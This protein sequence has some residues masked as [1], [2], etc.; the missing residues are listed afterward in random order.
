MQIEL[1]FGCDCKIVKK[2]IRDVCPPSHVKKTQ[3]PL[4]GFSWNFTLRILFKSVHQVQLKLYKNKGIVQLDLR[5]FMTNVITNVTM[6]T[7]HQG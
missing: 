3:L 6:V 2:R 5:V 1:I 4:D 7:C